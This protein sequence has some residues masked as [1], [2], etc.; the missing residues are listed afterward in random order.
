MRPLCAVVGPVV[1]PLWARSGRGYGAGSH[2]RY[3]GMPGRASSAAGQRG[4][5]VLTVNRTGQARSRID[6]YMSL[7]FTPT[8]SLLPWKASV[9][10]L[11]VPS[12][13]VENAPDV[14]PV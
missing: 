14:L 2:Y 3:G 8:I 13:N 7:K 12:S 4:N 11:V 10:T 5:M 6:A 9:Y 1:G